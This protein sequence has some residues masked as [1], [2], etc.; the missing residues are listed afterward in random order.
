M[1]KQR[2]LRVMVVGAAALLL[3]G[4]FHLERSS[5]ST[6]GVDGN[7]PSTGASLSGDGRF[8]AFESTADNLVPGDTNGKADVFVRDHQTHSTALVSV[9]A[10]GGVADGASTQASISDDGRYVAFASTATN[11]VDGDLDARSDVF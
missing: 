6:D 11:L 4:C 3:A 1:S 5:V 8:V 7:G 10:S 2:A 9:S